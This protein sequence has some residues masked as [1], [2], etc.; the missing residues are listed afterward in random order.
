MLLVALAALA[1]V[2]IAGPRLPGLELGSAIA[3]RI[4][5]AAGLSGGCEEDELTRAFGPDVAA[6]V[7]EHAPEL[8]YEPGMRALPVDFRD[9]REDACSLGPHSGAVDRTLE[10]LP[11][12]AYVGV[13]DCREPARAPAE[14]DCSG[15]R[16]GAL[17]LH[18]WLYYPGS[19]TLRAL[20]GEHGHHRDDWE[21]FQVRITGEEIY[22]RAS[23]HHGYNYRAG[24]RNWLSDA[25]VAPKP[26]WGP[27]TGT[28]YIAGGSHAGHAHEPGSEPERWTPSESIRLVPLPS[29]SDAERGTRFAVTPPWRKRVAFDPE[30]TGTE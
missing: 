26:G 18:Y 23:S 2:A 4:A 3:A 7:A 12:T 29:L 8:R 13:V 9:C 22:A 17:Y 24:V 27:A 5:C 19:Q 16:A 25:G 1:A 28:Y 6:L 11:V 20:L 10:G 14:V 21:S 30:H 15:R